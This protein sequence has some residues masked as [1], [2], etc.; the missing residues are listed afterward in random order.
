MNIDKVHIRHILLYEFHQKKT[1]AEAYKNICSVYGEGAVGSSTCREWFIKF[2]NGDFD[3]SD[4]PRSGRP[5]ELQPDD[6][7]MLL[8]EDD[9]QSS[10]QLAKRLN[11]DHSTVLRRLHEMG[12]ILKEGK[13]IP[14]EL[15]ENVATQRLNTCVSLLAKQIK[16]SFLWKI[17]TGDEKWIYFTNPKRKKHWV[18]LGTP[19]T[20]T[21]QRKFHETKVMLCI[22]W[23]EK[24][25]IYYELL[26][27][28][29]SITADRYSKQ[30]KQLSQELEK[31]RPFTGKGPR[32]VILLH[33]NARPH[34][35]KLTQKTIMEL[36][37]DVLPHPA[38]SPDL[39]PSDYHLFR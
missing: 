19:T 28:G 27:S 12:K 32:P 15:S 7:Q 31:K 14:H 34:V 17:V 6:L 23:D 29:E 3:L 30:L 38:Y 10:V 4:K 33:D 5:L 36:G 22:W 18:D 13:W 9:A 37:W 35:A 24:G 2:K 1:A 16:K 8:D 25:V 26:K 39:A 20:S 11:V 21:P